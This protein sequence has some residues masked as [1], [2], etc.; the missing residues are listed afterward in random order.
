[1]NTSILRNALSLLTSATDTGTE[2]E[3][4]RLQAIIEKL[5]RLRDGILYH[6]DDKTRSEVEQ[7]HKHA[8]VKHILEEWANCQEMRSKI[9]NEGLGYFYY[10]YTSVPCPYDLYQTFA[11]SEDCWCG[12]CEEESEN[13]S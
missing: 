7:E 5:E 10:T 3:Q 2:Q 13:E 8:L 1:M 4:S 12:N 11:R 9:D 6:E